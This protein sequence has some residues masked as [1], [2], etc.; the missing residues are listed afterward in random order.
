LKIKL[1]HNLVKFSFI[2]EYQEYAILDDIFVQKKEAFIKFDKM[3]FA[4]FADRQISQ[5]TQ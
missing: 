3:N 4:S 1:K 2:I 5:N